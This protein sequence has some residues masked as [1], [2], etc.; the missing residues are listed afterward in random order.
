MDRIIVLSAGRIVEQGTYRELLS[1]DGMFA[2]MAR[3]QGLGIQP[4]EIVEAEF[5]ESEVV[6]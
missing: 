5:A 2:R 6:A 1:A 3:Q 4:P